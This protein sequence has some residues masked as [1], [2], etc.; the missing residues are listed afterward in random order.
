LRKQYGDILCGID[1]VGRGSWAGPL[2]V[3]AV[4]LPKD[5]LIPN[6]TD[7]KQLSA[8]TRT[9]LAE[10][11]KSVA[12]AW[13][14]Y[15]V[16]PMLIDRKGLTWANATASYEAGQIILTKMKVDLFVIDQ[17][18]S[19]DLE[20]NVMMARADSL[21]HVTAAASVIAKAYRD[22][23]M[24]E[25]AVQYPDYHLESHKG[26]ISQAHKTAVRKHGKVRGL[27]RFSY[28]VDGINPDAGRQDLIKKS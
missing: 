15:S 5:V 23:L 17:M 2:V 8:S 4:V 21:S 27:H 6:L 20:P 22:N 10:Q 14:V 19:C 1:E 26:Y 12:L 18:P 9:K 28:K 3:G 24:T 11:I 16:E 13:A 7:S 25:L